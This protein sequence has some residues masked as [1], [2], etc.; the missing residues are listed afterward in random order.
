[1]REDELD[2]VLVVLLPDALLYPHAMVVE[3]ADADVA[4]L[5]VLAPRRL[6]DVAGLAPI[7]P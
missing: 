3:S 5:A 1:M 7:I 2:E 6:D 4:D